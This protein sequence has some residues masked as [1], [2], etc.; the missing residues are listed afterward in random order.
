MRKLQTFKVLSGLGMCIAFLTSSVQAQTTF[1]ASNAPCAS[2]EV[3]QNDETATVVVIEI[4]SG[5]HS[6]QAISNGT[7]LKDVETGIAYRMR[8]K[9]VETFTENGHT[10][11][12]YTLTFS[13]LD[14]NT[15]VFDLIDPQMQQSALYFSQ[16]SHQAFTEAKASR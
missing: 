12:S 14:P 5:C 8:G 9:E 13:S 7:I 10:R 16:V 2:I 1:A 3:K 6:N 4:P 11:H 15:A